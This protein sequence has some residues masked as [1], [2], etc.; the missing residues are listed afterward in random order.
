[1]RE[2]RRRLIHIKRNNMAL[3]LV[4]TI[5]I[6]GAVCFARVNLERE[7]ESKKEILA[8]YK[9]E[10]KSLK[11]EQKDMKELEKY[12]TSKEYIEDMAREK[13]GLV[14]ENEVI[15]EAED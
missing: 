4:F 3:V 5:A 2:R 8:T 6:L 15:F 12:V 9:K 1:M 7:L 11:E 14:Y 10:K 13:F